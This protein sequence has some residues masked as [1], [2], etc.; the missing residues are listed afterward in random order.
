MLAIRHGKLKT[1]LSWLGR[2]IQWSL[3]S[4][5]WK[6]TQEM[7]SNFENTPQCFKIRST[8]RNTK[9]GTKSV[10]EYYSRLIELWQ[11]M[12]LFYTIPWKCADDGVLY[13]KIL[14]KDR[15]FLFLSR[16]KQRSR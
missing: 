5:I 13:N 6:A 14:E 12:D 15:V 8:L 4:E 7:Y 1:Q 3:K 2:S 10:T 11:K 9:Q 16:F